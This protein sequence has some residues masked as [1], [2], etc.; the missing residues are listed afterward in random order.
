MRQP[1]SII[2]QI[3]AL[4]L[5]IQNPSAL[6]AETASEKPK[7]LLVQSYHPEYA[8]T[9]G[10]TRGVQE[11]LSQETVQLEIVYLDGK[12]H[13]N[14][15][16]KE[17][18]GAEIRARIQEWQPQVVITAD[19][20][21]Q[22]FVAQYFVSQLP[23][24]VFCGV[25]E[26]PSIYGFPASNVTG[27]LARPHMAHSLQYLRDVL[28]PSYSLRRLAFMADRDAT[29]IGAFNFIRKQHEIEEK[30][31]AYS[32]TNHYEQWKERVREFDRDADAIFF[33]TYHT[34]QEKEGEVSLEGAKVM[35][36]TIENMERP[37]VGFF[38]FTIQ[39][40]ALCG[41]VSSS[42]EHGRKAAGMV[43][44]ILKGTKPDMIPMVHAEEGLWMINLK[45]AKRL[46]LQ[47]SDA[48]L[49]SADKVFDA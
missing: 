42:E 38:D 30:V 11:I 16:W 21:A 37:S 31:V 26:D 39:E 45:T 6:A 29:S 36:W 9:A 28:G 14:V 12:R 24:F 25:N 4:L 48:I 1:L 46:G 20:D 7:I 35:K 40:G 33:Y 17:K 13:N 8:W 18:R 41:V 43:L 23:Y 47:I 19:D 3:A 49:K 22:A 5:L 34:I 27:I 2:F 32:L 15:A 10:I 44:E